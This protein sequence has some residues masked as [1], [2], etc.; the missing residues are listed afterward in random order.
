MDKEKVTDYVRWLLA[1]LDR[2]VEIDKSTARTMLLSVIGEIY[3]QPQETQS[4]T[5]YP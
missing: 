1:Q 4:G 2:M 5:L 3:S